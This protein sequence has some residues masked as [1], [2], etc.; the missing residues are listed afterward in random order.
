MIDAQIVDKLLSVLERETYLYV[1]LGEIAVQIQEIIVMNDAEMLSKR[2]NEE[3]SLLKRAEQ[4]RQERFSILMQIK[5]SLHLSDREL[6]LGKLLEFVSEADAAL[7]QEQR[8]RLADAVTRLE[9]INKTNNALVKYSLDLNAKFMNLLV[10]IG[11]N[12]TVYK[13]SGKISDQPNGKKRLLDKK[14]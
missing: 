7:I 13:P 1:R 11:Q 5:T 6:T 9:N 3:D 2:I 12:N 8:K 10:N 14:V 4:L